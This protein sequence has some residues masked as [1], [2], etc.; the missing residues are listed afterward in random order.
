M[1]QQAFSVRKLGFIWEPKD[2]GGGEDIGNW[3]E[4]VQGL[5]GLL[6]YVRRGRK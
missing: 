6:G 4:N 3:G 1:R 2:S 5:A